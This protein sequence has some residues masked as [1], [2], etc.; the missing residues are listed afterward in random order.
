MLINKDQINLIKN[1]EVCLVKNFVKLK[2][3]YDF[4]YISNILENNNL[5]VEQK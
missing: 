2:T 4:N 3:K 5:K 1:N